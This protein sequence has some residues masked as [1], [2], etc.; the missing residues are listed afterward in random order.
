MSHRTRTSAARMRVDRSHRGQTTA[1]RCTPSRAGWRQQAADNSPRLSADELWQQ[2]MASDPG[3][4]Q[5]RKL[6]Q[7]YRDA[8]ASGRLVNTADTDKE[9]DDE[10]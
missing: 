3:S 4:P 5:A 2:L 1:P 9:D 10:S 8:T 6:M 7:Q